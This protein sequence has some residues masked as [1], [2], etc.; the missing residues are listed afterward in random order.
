M[1]NWVNDT[2]AEGHDPAYKY[3]CLSLNKE[4]IRPPLPGRHFLLEW[5][6]CVCVCVCVCGGGGGGE[7][8]PR[9]LACAFFYV[10]SGVVFR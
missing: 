8:A 6:K 2:R 1:R 7:G 10:A 9:L 5:F 4:R 3:I